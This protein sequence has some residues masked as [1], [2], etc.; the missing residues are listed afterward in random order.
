ME[1]VYDVEALKIEPDN[2]ESNIMDHGDSRND[3]RK[4][5]IY[6]SIVCLLS[7]FSVYCSV[8]VFCTVQAKTEYVINGVT[9]PLDE[10][11]YRTKNKPCDFLDPAGN[12]ILGECK[13]IACTEYPHTNKPDRMG[14]LLSFLDAVSVCPV[15]YE[16]CERLK[17]HYNYR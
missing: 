4:Q 8:P 17:S 5:R 6:V 13:P 12:C 3:R 14:S 9:L 7:F 11:G 15:A 1:A 10:D 16:I 2:L